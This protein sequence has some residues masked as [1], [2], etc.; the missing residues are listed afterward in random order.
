MND[1]LNSTEDSLLKFNSAKDFLPLLAVLPVIILTVFQLF[2]QD[3]IWWCKLGDYAL[4]SNDAWG[5]H[6]SQHLFDPYS[7]THILHGV[8]FFWLASFVF[9]KI[10]LGWR[11]FAVIFVECAWEILENTNAIIEHY[12][13]A[14]LALDY[15]GDSIT[16]SVGDIFCCGVGFMLAYKLKFWRSLALFLL[17]EI[18]LLVWI[19]DSLLLNIIMLIHP[20][21]AVKAWQQ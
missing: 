3:R 16:N 20:I 17:I 18:V 21:E 5:K 9:G 7:F 2:N 8:L 6:N 13:T 11:F 19:R 10:S 1:N 12:R 4:W 15:Y 14:T